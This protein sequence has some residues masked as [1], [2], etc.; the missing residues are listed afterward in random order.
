MVLQLAMDMAGTF[1]ILGYLLIKQIFK[2]QVSAQ[3]YI[4]MLRVSIVLYLCPFQQ[5]KYL[6]LPE[7][8][9]ERF[10]LNDFWDIVGKKISEF[11]VVNIPSLFG[12]YYVVP[13]RFFEI[14]IVWITVCIIVIVYRYGT[15]FFIKRRIRQSGMKKEQL[16]QK[17]RKIEVFQSAKVK[18]PCTVG[19]ISPGIFIPEKNYSASEREWLLQHELT[20]I[21]HGD[22]FWKCLAMFCIAFHWYNPL[23]YYLFHEYS[24]MCEYYC[25]AECMQDSNIEEKKNYAIF[26]VKSATSVMPR[27]RLVIMQGLTNNG[28]KM[29]ERVDRIIDGN[30][31]PA[32][33]VCLLIAGIFSAMCI[34]SLMTVFV[35]SATQEQNIPAHD[36]TFTEE[37]WNYFYGEDDSAGDETLD[38]N[39]SSLLFQS[40]QGKIIPILRSDLM[41]AQSEK[42]QKRKKWNHEMEEGTLKMHVAESGKGC[43][44]KAYKAQRCIKCEQTEYHELIYTADY[45]SCSHNLK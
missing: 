23:V 26:L 2:K 33:N 13:K 38:F 39:A 45:A 41:N 42:G 9:L 34:C 35:Y 25:D 14:S 4:Q 28:E 40:K 3:K 7:K 44:I 16:C 27:S 15:Y 43:R 20:H 12:D 17:G 1:P 21:R 32:G 30:N 8:L 19:W 24:V 22:V 11:K 6:I 5:F 10:N 37:E 31:R 18:T 36:N 29:Q